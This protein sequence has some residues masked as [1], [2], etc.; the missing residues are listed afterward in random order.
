MGKPYRPRRRKSTLSLRDIRCAVHDAEV[1]TEDAGILLGRAHVALERDVLTLRQQA[2]AL[3]AAACDQLA[4]A[5]ASLDE[6]LSGDY[7][8]HSAHHDAKRLLSQTE[9][10]S[11]R[12]LAASS[13]IAGPSLT[14]PTVAPHE[15]RGAR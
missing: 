15:G 10:T 1:A 6:K 4:S 8:S 14:A 11:A 7:R 13:K 5:I 12:A 2:R 3:M 9:P